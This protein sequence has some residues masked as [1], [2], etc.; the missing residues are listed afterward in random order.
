MHT[1]LY[2]IT[3]INFNYWSKWELHW[4]KEGMKSRLHKQ[5]K[6]IYHNVQIY[7]QPESLVT[8]TNHLETMQIK[9]L[10]LTVEI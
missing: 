3:D 2:S 6:N 7:S 10:S 5:V 1:L 9:I 8:S 4:E